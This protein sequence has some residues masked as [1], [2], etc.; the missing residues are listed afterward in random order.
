[1]R[2]VIGACPVPVVGKIENRNETQASVQKDGAGVDE[3]ERPFEGVGSK[4]VLSVDKIQKAFLVRF[5]DGLLPPC[6]ILVDVVQ[7]VIE[8]F[9]QAEL[10]RLLFV[11]CPTAQRVSE[12]AGRWQQ[13]HPRRHN[14]VCR[15]RLRRRQ[16]NRRA[17][18]RAPRQPNTAVP[19]Q[20]SPRRPSTR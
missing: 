13:P 15:S 7:S 9:H 2:H 6:C 14:A 20:R 11:L 3:R 8:L 5:P 18:R 17:A 16:R 19:Q 4:S 1:M 12:L 10:Q